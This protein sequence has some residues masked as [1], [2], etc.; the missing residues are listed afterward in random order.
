MLETPKYI[1]KNIH[2]FGKVPLVN[3]LCKWMSIW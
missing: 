2:Y 1:F 3:G